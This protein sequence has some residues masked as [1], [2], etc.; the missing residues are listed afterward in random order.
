MVIKVVRTLCLIIAVAWTA[1]SE[2]AQGSDKHKVL[3]DVRTA[4]QRRVNSF[5]CVKIAWQ[6]SVYE[7]LMETDRERARAA[8]FTNKETFWIA[9]GGKRRHM[10][11]G[12]QSDV[13]GPSSV[14][15]HRV[16][17]DDGAGHWRTLTYPSE[18]FSSWMGTLPAQPWGQQSYFPVTLHLTSRLADELAQ[19][20]FSLIDRDVKIGGTRAVLLESAAKSPSR[21]QRMALDPARDYCVIYYELIDRHENVILRFDIEYTDHPS[22]LWVPSAWIHENYVPGGALIDHREAVV[23]N[24]EVSGNCSDTLFV[25]P[26]P[27]GTQVFDET[28]QTVFT[29]G[30]DGKLV[31]SARLSHDPQ[32]AKIP[33]QRKTGVAL[34]IGWVAVLILIVWTVRCRSR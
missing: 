30:A 33:L 34:V 8:R 7:P 27:S 17:T 23:S 9:R 11:Q 19:T 3:V 2:A 18:H 22:G 12:V 13:G 1:E 31:K 15:L 26:F 6:A 29:A 16:F 14:S 5:G 25:V 10:V 4:I 24:V 20:E 32:P 28:Q 21:R